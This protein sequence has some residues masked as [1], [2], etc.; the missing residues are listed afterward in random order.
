MES[1]IPDHLLC[2]RQRPA[3]IA[4]GFRP[5]GRAVVPRFAE[6]VSAVSVAY[7]GLQHPPPRLTDGA[8]SAATWLIDQL[9]TA[10]GPG[11]MDVTEFT[12]GAGFRNLL[13]AC[14]WPGRGVEPW[15]QRIGHRWTGDASL[16]PKLGRF[17]EIFTPTVDRIDA[18]TDGAA[19]HGLA[20]LAGR[21][22]GPVL[23][24]G[25]WGAMRDRIAL[26]QTDAMTPHG[27]FE[28]LAEG[29][30]LKV[31]PPANLCVMRTSQDWSAAGAAE[32]AAYFD[33]LEPTMKAGTDLLQVSGASLGCVCSRYTW[34]IGGT[35]ENQGASFGMS[36]WRSLIDLERW[37]ESH[38]MHQAGH[39]ASVRHAARFGTASQIS[40]YHEVLV[41]S[42]RQ[43]R[44]E[45]RNCHR[46]TGVLTAVA[47]P[48]AR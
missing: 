25:Y 39:E 38:P 45:Y 5:P 6:S 9:Q 19:L 12:D 17:A 20:R 46:A 8:W 41:P 32:R 15:W 40:R 29:D 37:A 7:F 43:V 10:D 31:H 28:L 44:F 30:L 18:L 26:S 23:E 21:T 24:Q 13:W 27:R 42:E 4:D 22:S 34:P 16:F 35:R 47:T 36:I 33:E 11:H 2:P 3:R 1:A 48:G 14:Y